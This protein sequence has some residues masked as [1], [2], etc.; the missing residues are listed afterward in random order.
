MKKLLIVGLLAGLLAPNLSR[1]KLTEKEQSL[2]NDSEMTVGLGGG[3]NLEGGLFGAADFLYNPTNSFGVFGLRAGNANLNKLYRGQDVKI[4]GLDIALTAGYWSNQE[5]TN[6]WG[7]HVFVG[8]GS[9]FLKVYNSASIV[10]LNASQP[11]KRYGGGVD[12]Y[13]MQ[14]LYENALSLGLEF[15]WTSRSLLAKDGGKFGRGLEDLSLT[16]GVRYWFN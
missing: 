7:W 11:F 3:S 13:L 5:R 9:S 10:A 8:M 15:C 12:Y 4:T 16:L 14:N 6:L 2:K 1:A